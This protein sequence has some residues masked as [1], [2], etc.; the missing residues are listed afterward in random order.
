MN[1]KALPLTE[2]LGEL[3]SRLTKALL[4]WAAGFAASWS[5]REEIFGFI[6]KPA[7]ASL[8]RVGSSSLQAIAPTE[9]FFTY[10]KAALLAGFFL[11][12]PVIFWQVWAFV[13]PGLY[14]REKRVAAPFVVVSTA[15]FVLGAAFGH[16]IMFPVMFR[17]LAG[18][19]SSF[20]E[21]AWTMR[22]V[23]ALISRLFLAL[24]VSFELPVAIFFLAVTGLV[25]ARQLMKGLPYA[26][27]GAVVL[28]AVLTPPDIISQLF[29]AGPLVLLY[30]VGV[31]VA[32]LVG[33]RRR[34]ETRDT[35][36]I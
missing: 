11:A 19:E 10:L 6:L 1:D 18:F 5:Y 9:I 32:F 23:F 24:G 30:L 13:S 35:V 27:L 16:Q 14:P 25:D 31:G 8:A 34:R 12:L 21:S 28:G 3:R 33:R 29:L 22:E 4:A 26:F 7:V 17:F 2:H 20:V 15:L 36:P